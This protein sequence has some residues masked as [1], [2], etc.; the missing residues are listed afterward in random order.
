MRYFAFDATNSISD[1]LNENIFSGP[2]FMNETFDKVLL[3]G[4]CTGMGNRPIFSTSLTYSRI[5]SFAKL[6]KKINDNS[7]TTFE[8]RWNFSLKHLHHFRS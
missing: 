3:D 2:P 7:R 8:N 4:S 6:Q 1:D 5:I